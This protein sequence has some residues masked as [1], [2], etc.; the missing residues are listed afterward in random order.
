V[1]AAVNI[2]WLVT[3]SAGIVAW[4]LIIVSC[5]WG[6]LLATRALGRKASPAWLLSLHRF[7]GALAVVFTAIHVIAILL[8]DFVSFDLYAVLIP[9]VSSWE[10]IA[11]ALGIIGMYLLVAIEV[12]SLLRARLSPRAWRTVHLLSY[13]LFAITTVH[14]LAAGTD[15]HDLIPTGIAVVIGAVAVFAGATLWWNRSKVDRGPRAGAGVSP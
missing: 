3:R 6:L 10:P 14:A 12:T 8:D 15:T 9:F 13:A 2:S 7:L 5:V 1:L 11:V 4:A